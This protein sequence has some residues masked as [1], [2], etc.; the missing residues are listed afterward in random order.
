[1]P[2][3]PPLPPGRKP[4]PRS[5][6]LI[7]LPES[8]LALGKATDTRSLTELTRAQISE[9]DLRAFGQEIKGNSDRTACI[10]LS[11][12]IERSLEECLLVYLN[13]T[14]HNF[15]KLLLDRDGTLSSFSA[16]IRLGYALELYNRDFMKQFDVIRRIRNAFAHSEIPITFKTEAVKHE[17]TKLPLSVYKPFIEVLPL[18]IE[19]QPV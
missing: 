11:S 16:N 14:D 9:E 5:R 3:K 2:P 10:V 18:T 8:G 4:S 15:R 17:L 13:I 19:P 6:R 7:H 12:M 1:V